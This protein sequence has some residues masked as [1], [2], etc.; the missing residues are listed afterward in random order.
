M[1]NRSNKRPV[2]T[3]GEILKQNFLEPLDLNITQAAQH[4]GVTRVTLSNL[5]NG[6]NLSDEMAKRLSIATQTS[7]E[8]WLNA[9]LM[10]R[11]YNASQIEVKT[12]A[13]PKVA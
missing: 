9:E 7:I 12:T 13:F 8:Y 5:V 2:R 3:V 11:A 4:L 10:R 6:G 1:N